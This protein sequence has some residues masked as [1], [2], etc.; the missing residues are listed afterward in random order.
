MS[1]ETH[2]I[3][4]RSTMLALYFDYVVFMILILFKLHLIIMYIT[5]L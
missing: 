5:V 4:T 1:D 2:P 3:Y